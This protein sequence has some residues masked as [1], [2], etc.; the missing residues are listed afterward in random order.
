MPVLFFV[1]SAPAK[2]L[3]PTK[4][5]TPI[6]LIGPKASFRYRAISAPF[7]GIQLGTSAAIAFTHTNQPLKLP[8]TRGA[9]PEALAGTPTGNLPSPRLNKTG[10]GSF[11]IK[12]ENGQCHCDTEIGDIRKGRTA[13]LIAEADFSLLGR[14]MPPLLLVE[15]TY[16]DSIEIKI[17]GIAVTARNTPDDPSYLAPASRPHGDLLETIK[18][19]TYPG[20]L[21]SD[22]NTIRVTI[23]P[24][25]LRLG[26]IFSMRLLAKYNVG[27][28]YSPMVGRVT[29]TSAVIQFE[30]DLPAQAAIRYWPE[31]RPHLAKIESSSGSNLARN[32]VV[33]LT[34]LPQGQKII[35]QVLVPETGKGPAGVRH[36]D[37]FRTSRGDG[38]PIRFSVYGDMRDG[39]EIHGQILKSIEKENPDFVVV[40]GDLV[41]RGTDEGDWQRF[42][43]I[44]GPLLANTPYY[45]V[46]GNHDLG[47]TGNERKRMAELFPLWPGPPDRGKN[48]YYA[49]DVGFLHFVMLDSNAYDEPD[50][51]RWLE[52]HLQ[53]LKSRPMPKDRMGAP[54]ERQTIVVTHDGPYSRG[55]HGGNEVA[56]KQYLPLLRKY[57][58]NL[59]LA[60]HDHLYQ[61]GNASGLR[62]FVSGGGGAALYNIKCGVKNKR[63]CKVRDGMQHIAKAYHYINFEVSRKRITACTKK[64]N[65][66]PLEPCVTWRRAID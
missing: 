56:R 63:R 19:P 23:R 30:T 8:E 12:D 54:L 43:S 39:H 64:P 40:T 9:L 32:H 35:Y 47:E 10:N 11:G 53:N 38:S 26:P 29:T 36:S 50:Q 37:S 1:G 57:G 17:N 66:A 41:H 4:S 27:L 31:S 18:I 45:P 55:T 20:L 3:P 13:S 2:R 6:E 25:S 46:T 59:L 44:A 51:L 48:H 7:P 5:R 65:G 21:R 15:T 16:Q 62:Y 33:S 58:V 22:D 60:G 61:R 49:F 34:G 28:V 14:A 24:S 52:S 42:F